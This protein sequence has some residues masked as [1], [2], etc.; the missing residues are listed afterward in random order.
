VTED[1]KQ[2]SDQL[3][4]V[5]RLLAVLASAGESSLRDKSKVLA[6]AG[7]KPSDIAEV[8]GTTANTVRVELSRQRKES[9][10]GKQ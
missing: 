10:R 6:R 8:L 1:L 2:V 4:V 3:A 9:R 5:I 7:L